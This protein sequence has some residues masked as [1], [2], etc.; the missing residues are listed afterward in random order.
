MMKSSTQSIQQKPS[1]V[2]APE[3]EHG[4]MLVAC[5]SKWVAQDACDALIEQAVNGGSGTGMKFPNIAKV[6]V[7]APGSARSQK[8]LAARLRLAK[9]VPDNVT[10]DVVGCGTQ[11]SFDFLSNEGRGSVLPH[12][13]RDDTVQSPHV[14]VFLQGVAH[15][16]DVQL[17][18]AIGQYR[19]AA[20][21]S[22]GYVVIVMHCA[23][24]FE[25]RGLE[26][27]SDDYCVVD[28]CEPDPGCESALTFSYPDLD[29]LHRYGLGRMMCGLRFTDGRI[30]YDYTSYIADDVKNRLIWLLRAGGKSLQEIGDVVNL[31]KANVMRRLRDMPVVVPQQVDSERVKVLLEHVEL[32]KKNPQSKKDKALDEEI[33]DD[34]E[35]ELTTTK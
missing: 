10:L 33:D 24:A 8:A 28:E 14:N 23:S 21:K 22:N 25:K 16:R 30:H 5:S 17:A 29:H 27:V 9:P 18:E 1:L 4:V 7:F 32:E 13:H 2:E 34:D 19:V 15:D 12:I 31:D 35:E 6:R 20:Q 11:S 26:D 3:L